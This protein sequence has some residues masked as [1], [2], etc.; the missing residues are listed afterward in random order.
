MQMYEK[1]IIGNAITNTLTDLS[2]VGI[3]GF[4]IT[5]NT[6]GSVTH[7]PTYTDYKNNPTASKLREFT[8][9]G[10]K[11]NGIAIIAGFNC[12]CCIDFDLKNTNQ[13]DLFERWKKLIS[14][15]TLSKCYIEITRNNGYHVFFFCK[16]FSFDAQPAA[17][18]DGR[19]VIEFFCKQNKI[20]YTFP[21]PGYAEVNISLYDTG[22]VSREEA[23]IMLHTAELFNCY[24]GKR[25][26]YT[27]GTRKKLAYPEGKETLFHDF[28]YR[29]DCDILLDWF[30]KRTRWRQEY[31]E[32]RKEYELWHPNAGGTAR[33]AVYFVMT[34]RLIVHSET[35][36]LF[37]T[38][39]S[40][41]PENPTPY[42]ITPTHI[43]YTLCD[44]DFI[45]VERIM[46]QLLPIKIA[47]RV[48]RWLLTY[49]DKAYIK[50]SINKL[51]QKKIAGKSGY[52]IKVD[53]YLLVYLMHLIDPEYSWTCEGTHDECFTAEECKDI[54]P[55]NA[56][57]SYAFG[58][59][60]FIDR[61]FKYPI[62]WDL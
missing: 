9:S 12:L 14:P 50:S 28:D 18:E 46:K 38:W 7:P 30:C 61:N 39:G 43:L 52:T 17:N 45:E 32:R 47:F 27:P 36:K 62:N 53:S 15:E 34:N 4:P 49:I 16:N 44:Q 8:N 31:N 2:E 20:V 35:Q 56:I 37:P 6:D 5:R 11:A 40:Y 51:G 3:Y 48:K 24:K 21:T 57:L 10:H 41:D 60:L 26:S 13:K 59:T 19:A 58:Q 29:V 54:I 42:V 22:E 33:S 25:E 23:L 55:N 1:A